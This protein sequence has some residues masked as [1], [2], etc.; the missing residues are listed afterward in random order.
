VIFYTSEH[1]VTA[2]ISVGKQAGAVA[3]TGSQCRL[4]TI[5]CSLFWVLAR[6]RLPTFRGNVGPRGWELE[7]AKHQ[8][9]MPR[10][11]P[12]EQ[13]P[14]WITRQRKPET[15]HGHSRCSTHTVYV[16]AFVRVY[17]VLVYSSQMFLLLT[18][19][20]PVVTLCTAQQ[21]L[22]VPHSG[23]YMYRTMVTVC[24]ARFNIRKSHVLPA[25]CI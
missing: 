16:S 8:Q 24:T 18:L 1:S 12:E 6:R 22:Y 2:G 14:N 23:H 15:C 11:I 25:Q 17:F 4:P 9:P 20:S 13:R 19:Q 7:V 10:N 5:R 3:D 21:S